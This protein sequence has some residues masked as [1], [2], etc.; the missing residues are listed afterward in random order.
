MFVKLVGLWL[1]VCHK[2]CINSK[3]IKM[4]LSYQDLL[5]Q[6]LLYQDLLYQD[7]LYQDLTSKGSNIPKSN[8][9]SA[10]YGP[11][12]SLTCWLVLRVLWPRMPLGTLV[13]EGRQKWRV[14]DNFSF[15]LFFC[16]RMEEWGTERHCLAEGVESE[17]RIRLSFYFVIKHDFWLFLLTTFSKPFQYKTRKY[18]YKTN[19]VDSIKKLK[20]NNVG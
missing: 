4:Y 5:S 15:F 12:L 20:R 16:L 18:L 14:N 10:L 7:L 6:G 8:I 17:K 2:K 13:K 11:P 9:Q 19:W 3:R 1:V